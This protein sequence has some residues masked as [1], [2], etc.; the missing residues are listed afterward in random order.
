MAGEE[1]RSVNVTPR[2][3]NLWLATQI[4]PFIKELA[5]GRDVELGINVKRRG[6]ALL[7][8]LTVDGAE[9]P[10]IRVTAQ[11]R[12]SRLA[13]QVRDALVVGLEMTAK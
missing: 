9:M 1:A 7:V 6:T 8:I 13:I 2:Q 4:P 11:T 3:L 12:M 10:S 5:A